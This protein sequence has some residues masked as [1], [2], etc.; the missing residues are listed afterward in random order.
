MKCHLNIQYY[1]KSV[2]LREKRDSLIIN[3]V[4]R[5]DLN[6]FLDNVPFKY[7][8]RWGLSACAFSQEIRENAA[9]NNVFPSMRV[10]GWRPFYSSYLRLCWSNIFDGIKLFF[11][12]N[13]T[14]FAIE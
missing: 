9:Q 13:N 2:F 8:K 6:C 10:Y 12:D 4:F 7:H 1:L 3:Y 11:Q 14:V 5:R